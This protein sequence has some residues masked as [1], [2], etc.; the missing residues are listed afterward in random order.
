MRGSQCKVLKAGQQV[1]EDTIFETSLYAV[2]N[3]EG[4]RQGGYENKLKLFSTKVGAERFIDSKPSYKSE[5]V[6]RL[7]EVV[8]KEV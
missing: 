1:V 8:L 2:V 7:V 4:V 6:W 5:E 3:E